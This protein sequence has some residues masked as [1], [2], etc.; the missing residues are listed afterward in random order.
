MWSNNI[1]FIKSP[2]PTPHVPLLFILVSP[3]PITL[4]SFSL[5]TS[6]N[7][8][9][10]LLTPPSMLT[11]PNIT[12]YPPLIILNTYHKLGNPIPMRCNSPTNQSPH[13]PHI[14]HSLPLLVLGSMNHQIQSGPT[15]AEQGLTPTDLWAVVRGRLWVVAAGGGLR[16]EALHA[17]CH[18]FRQ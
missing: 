14:T 18:M 2:P 15:H 16:S 8:F 11:F 6:T 3:N 10:I 9:K 13:S 7:K 4:I 12:P 5:T 1:K 17:N